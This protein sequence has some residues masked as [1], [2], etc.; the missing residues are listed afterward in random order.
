MVSFLNTK[1]Y[2]D[3]QLVL[4]NQ[5]KSQYYRQT[6]SIK[7]SSSSGESEHE[8]EDDS[9]YGSLVEEFMNAEVMVERANEYQSAREIFRRLKENDPTLTGIGMAQVAD[10]VR[11]I[12]DWEQLGEIIACNSQIQ[13]L[14]FLNSRSFVA[15]EQTIV[16]CFRG[17][18]KSNSIDSVSFWSNRLSAVGMRS[19]VPFLQ[20]ANNLQS[21]DP[22]GTGIES[23]GFNILIRA[24]QNSPI[25]RLVCSRCGIESIE[26]ENKAFPKKLDSLSLD[27]NGLRADGIQGLMSLLQNPNDL[28]YL[29]ISGN[30]VT[31]EGFSLL[32]EGLRHCSIKDL[33]CSRCG[34]ASI[35]IDS[36]VIPR[37]LRYLGLCGNSI[38]ADGCREVAKLL[39]RRDL[40]LIELYLA[41]NKI[42]DEGVAIIARALQ[43]NVSLR[44][45]GL[46]DNPGITMEGTKLLLKLLNDVSSI[47]RTLQS[48][49]TL[50][51]LHSDPFDEDYSDEVGQQIELA[52]TINCKNGGHADNPSAGREKV[53]QFQLNSQNRSALSR[54]LGISQCNEALFSEIKPIYLPEVIELIS[55]HHGQ[56]ELYVALISSVAAL[57]S[58]VN[59]KHCLQQ[60][61]AH[62][63]AKLKEI[64]AEIAAIDASEKVQ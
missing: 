33:C 60:Q 53:I 50:Q 1:C 29:D 11:T 10:Y 47:N 54:Q 17:L 58:T 39:Q 16:S 31:P 62:L 24:L 63:E 35:A 48:N 2:D 9:S 43:D 28:R 3:Q 40:A 55:R 41:D 64:E 19:M 42:D 14:H 12:T 49:H 30:N 57:L 25:D 8:D 4:I 38:D 36:S 5:L 32:F 18:T 7:M 46:D 22:Q 52:L 26:G 51:S 61:K 13:V 34:L 6:R 23:E 59:R 56:G 15:D 44:L 20:N 27:N 21:L 37:N 45:L